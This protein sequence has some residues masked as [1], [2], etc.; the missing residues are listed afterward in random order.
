MRDRATAKVCSNEHQ[1]E[2]GPEK[3]FSREMEKLPRSSIHGESIR[4]NQESCHYRFFAVLRQIRYLC[5]EGDGAKT[6]SPNAS[7]TWKF[8]TAVRVGL[9]AE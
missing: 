4:K 8:G 5:G 3:T 7:G 9:Q 1:Q 2:E 6:N